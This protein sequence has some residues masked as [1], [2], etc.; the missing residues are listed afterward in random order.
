[1]F[2]KNEDLSGQKFGRWLVVNLAQAGSKRKWNCV[3]DCGTSRGVLAQALKRGTST[4]CG[5]FQKEK[6]AERS[7][8]HGLTKFPGYSNFLEMHDRCYNAESQAYKYYGAVGVYV[9]KDIWEFDDFIKAIGPK[10]S[11][12][13]SIG[14]I[15]N[16][17]PYRADN[18]RWETKAQQA[19]NRWMI[20]SNKSGVTGVHLSEDV[21]DGVT[22]QRWIGKY[23]NLD[24]KQ[25]KKSF[26]VKKF[27]FE[28]AKTLATEFRENGIKSLQAL[29]ADYGEKH[30][31]PRELEKN[32]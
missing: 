7:I 1:M 10:P 28:A 2:C 5:C 18:I 24:G 22:Y 31:L 32:E 11:D 15:D 14:R 8:T 20:S 29:G 27:G 9:E 30:G 25:K 17:L 19:R 12:E 23:T 6:L 21:V 3:C 4:S 13:H 26:S 16:S